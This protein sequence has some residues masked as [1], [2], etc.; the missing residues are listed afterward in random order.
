MSRFR[1][2]N[3]CVCGVFVVA[4]IA[5]PVASAVMLP[6]YGDLTRIGAH[7]EEDFGWREPQL[8]LPAPHYASAA[9]YVG[10][11]D[12]VILGDSFSA[13]GDPHNWIAHLANATGLSIVRLNIDL[14]DIDDVVETEA[15]RATPPRFVIYQSAERALHDRVGERATRCEPGPDPTPDPL[16]LRPLGIRPIAVPP[17]TQP[18]FGD[19]ALPFFMARRSLPRLLMGFDDPL[20]RLRQL[21]RDAPFSS[22]VRNRLLF[23]DWDASV[24]LTWPGDAAERIACGLLHRQRLTQANGQTLFIALSTPDKLTA[25]FDLLE[26]RSGLPVSHLGEVCATP[27]LHVARADL[28]L[29]QAI[30]AGEVDVYL[31]NDTHWGSTGHQIAARELIREMRAL[32]AV[33]DPE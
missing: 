20:T 17:P 2:Y 5:A 24:K 25:Y 30:S 31:P 32:G 13:P 4:G 15:F 18:S 21:R 27:G 1:V 9:A 3:L 6:F 19:Y 7:L 29:A 28:A 26:D 23:F 12:V 33:R 14:F 16:V 11:A 8:E 10:H 22:R